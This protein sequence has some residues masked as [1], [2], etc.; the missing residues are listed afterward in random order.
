MTL[1]NWKMRQFA[2]IRS[3]GP[4]IQNTRASKF[5]PPLKNQLRTWM[6]RH[7]DLN[8]ESYPPSMSV[9]KRLVMT[10]AASGKQ[11]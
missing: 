6:L 11:H 5:A 4:T 10:K 8:H 9:T 3:S 7:L 1:Q 2:V